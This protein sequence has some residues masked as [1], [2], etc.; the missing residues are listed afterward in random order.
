VFDTI[1]DRNTVTIP[2]DKQWQSKQKW[3]VVPDPQEQEESVRYL[4]YGCVF[5]LVDDMDQ[6]YQTFQAAPDK[7]PTVWVCMCTR[8][9]MVSYD[10]KD[11]NTS[12][13]NE[14][15][16]N[17]HKVEKK[18]GYDFLIQTC[19]AF[20]VVEKSSYR[21]L[22]HKDWI[23]CKTESIRSTFGDIFLVTVSNVKKSIK[24]AIDMALLPPFHINVDLWTSK[25]TGEKYLGV[26]VFWKIGKVIK[27]SL[28]TV[29]VYNPLKIEG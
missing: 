10:I 25:V 7:Y 24:S 6:R 17:A 29:T 28:I 27:S 9:C 11:K 22:M 21:D 16:T 2:D 26:R 19:Q 14:H 13:M 18:M 1:W 8:K 3:L 5:R 20:V 15:V 12:P 4:T 23:P